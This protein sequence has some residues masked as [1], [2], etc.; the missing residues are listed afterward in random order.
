MWI[1]SLP[2]S[3]QVA[4]SGW[5]AVDSNS[6]LH[7]AQVYVNLDPAGAS[8]PSIID[9]SLSISVTV[10]RSEG[11][12][13]SVPTTS[14]PGTHRVGTL[15]TTTSP[16]GT[17]R[18]SDKSQAAV[19]AT[20]PTRTTRLTAVIGSDVDRSTFMDGA[21]RGAVLPLSRRDESGQ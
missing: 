17:Y 12:D 14:P 20:P 18:Y 19:R 3:G 10:R 1:R 2:H 16:V 7:A 8:F 13:W 21:S 15:G 11:T 6:V 4:S 5:S 9:R